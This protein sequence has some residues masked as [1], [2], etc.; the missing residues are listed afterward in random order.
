MGSLGCLHF[1]R[2]GR[3]S[4]RL[5]DRGLR[6]RA[7]RS[8]GAW[9]FVGCPMPQHGRLPRLRLQLQQGSE[10]TRRHLW[11]CL[12][13]DISGL[14]QAGPLDGGVRRTTL[15]RKMPGTR[16]HQRR[17]AG[18]RPP[19]G[20]T[21]APGDVFHLNFG[22]QPIRRA[23]RATCIFAPNGRA[24]Q[25]LSGRG[26]RAGAMCWKDAWLFLGCQALQHGCLPTMRLRLQQGSATI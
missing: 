15:S 24:S 3:T 4:Q 7:V 2:D 9:L 10:T 6:A 1:H 21:K 19:L 11:I 25:R 18:L 12:T 8:N 13:F 26:L 22:K 20:G 23:A 16:R 5:S 17:G 14:P